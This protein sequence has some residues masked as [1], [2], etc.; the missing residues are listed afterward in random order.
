M[1]TLTESIYDHPKYYDLVFGSDC[2]A[3]VKFICDANEKFLGGKARHLFEPACGTCRLLFG[4]AKKGFSVSG[5]DLNEKAVA[6]GNQRFTRNG[7]AAT[8]RV[9]DMSDFRVNRKWDLAF[10][11]INSFRHLT[12]ARSAADH[13]HCMAAGTK[14]GGIYL[15]GLHLTPTAIDPLDEEAW[16]AR[17]G[18]LTVNTQM[19]TKE[20]N[21]R[22]RMDRYGIRFDI[23]TPTRQFSIIDELQMRSYTARQFQ[24]M[25]DDQPD[26]EIEAAYDFA[27][28][29]RQPINIDAKTEDTV[30]VLRRI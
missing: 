14:K 7:L 20:R 21:S 1:Q 16:S 13:L 10:N 5:I 26:W 6:F 9:A 24:K 27:Y 2:A 23:Y 8:A 17:R 28:D 15:L 22:K 19:W 30:Y 3:E 12:T 11:T 25:I 29:I 4:L 18:H